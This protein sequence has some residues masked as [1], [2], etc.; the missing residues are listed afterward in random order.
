[1]FAGDP[2]GGLSKEVQ[3]GSWGRCRA[4]LVSKDGVAP[5]EG[6]GLPT[7]CVVCG[8]RSCEYYELCVVS[9]A[10]CASTCVSA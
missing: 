9:I 10:N 2:Y 3:R 6:G 8:S 4:F 1:M 7:A 5:N